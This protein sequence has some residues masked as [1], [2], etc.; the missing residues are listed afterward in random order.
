MRM[1]RL[2]EIN[3]QDWGFNFLSVDMF[4]EVQD[5]DDTGSNNVFRHVRLLL[6][7]T[8]LLYL[9]EYGASG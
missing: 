8:Q 3:E 5:V 6:A 9:R 7:V 4:C 2:P 1:K